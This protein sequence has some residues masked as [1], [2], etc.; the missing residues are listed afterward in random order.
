MSE[1]RNSIL[2]SNSFPLNNDLKTKTV[3]NTKETVFNEAVEN[4]KSNFTPDN[5]FSKGIKTLLRSFTTEASN[6]EKAINNASALL[7]PDENHQNSKNKNEVSAMGIR[8]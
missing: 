3:V 2:Q 1:I 4:N 5:T 6:V 7:F 8:G